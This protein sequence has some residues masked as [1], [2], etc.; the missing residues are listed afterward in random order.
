[1]SF[2]QP[3]NINVWYRTRVHDLHHKTDHMNQRSD[4]AKLPVAKGAAFDSYMDQHEE[5]CLPQTR[6]ELLR[7]IAAW[8]DDPRGQ[9]IFWLNGMAGTGKSTIA[10]TVAESFKRKELL[11]ASFFFKRGEGDRGNA[12]R[13]F[14]TI[15][16]QLVVQIPSL[17]PYIAQAIE[18]DPTLSEKSLTEQFDKLLLQPLS[19]WES[20]GKN[21]AIVIDALDEC[22][23]EKDIKTILRLLPRAKESSS[24]R[25]RVLVTSRPDLPIRLGFSQIS[26]DDHQDMVLHKIPKETI[27][28]DIEVFFRHRFDQIK[29]ERR[30]LS[31]DWPG[32]ENIQTLVTMAVPLFIFAATVCRFVEDPKWNPEKRLTAILKSQAISHSKLDQT[33]SPILNQLLLDQDKRE[34][35]QLIEEFREIVGVIIILASP[36]SVTSLARLLDIPEE[37]ISCRLDSL[38]SFLS[39]PSDL[40]VPVRLLHLS[41]RDFLLD[42]EKEGTSQ[43]WVDGRERHR[44]VAT[45]CLTVMR[46]GF[47]KNICN[48]PGYGTL[49]TEIDS[50]VI[51]DYVPVE[52]QYA[53]RYW[54]HHLQESSVD[55]SDQGDVHRFLQEHL[56]H[57]LEA[58]SISGIA[59]DSVKFIDDLWSLVQVNCQIESILFMLINLVSRR[60]TPKHQRFFMMQNVWC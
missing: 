36:L 43:F 13:F 40:N 56:L 18:A 11:G 20:C 29:Q 30:S 19:K 35:E 42:P 49:R 22:D 51:D 15:A 34:S 31:E 57:W 28:H 12:T 59:S 1:V 27:E 8:S 24:I 25:L 7:R 41:F 16:R 37:E 52:L 60:Q 21:I 9:S 47:K 32:E 2:V 44:K 33:Y 10:R 50:R 53:C 26:D 4:L 23:Q 45:Q 38:H 5:R 17:E 3:E 6:T 14:P 54:V 48:L 39:I 58:M 55:I 46:R